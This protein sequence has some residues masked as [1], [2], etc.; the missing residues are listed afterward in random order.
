VTAVPAD[1]DVPALDEFGV[2]RVGTRWVALSPVEEAVTRPLLEALGRP[3][4]RSALIAAAWPARDRSPRTLDA[5]VHR[6]RQRVAP[7]GL[8][9]HTVRGRGFVLDGDDELARQKNV[10]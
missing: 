5:T 1:A 2:L 8:L 4:G 7:L 10:S 3:V 6:I 9:I